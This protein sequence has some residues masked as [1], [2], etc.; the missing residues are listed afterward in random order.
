MTLRVLS[1]ADILRCWSMRDAIDW[2]RD[3][4]RLYSGGLVERGLHRWIYTDAPHGV[5]GFLPGVIK[6]GGGFGIKMLSAF[7]DEVTT[8]YVTRGLVLVADGRTGEPRA[9]LEGGAVTDLRTGAATGL[10]I[11]LLA[12][13]SARVGAMFGAGHVA[14]NQI[15]AMCEIRDIETVWLFSRTRSKALQFIETM[16][17]KGGRIPR[18]WHLASSPREAVADA[19]IVITATTTSTPLF[20]GRDLRQGACVIAAGGCVPESGEVDVETIRRCAKVVVDM[21]ET[22]ACGELAVPL[23]QGVIGAADVAELGE[24]VLSSR[25]GRERDDEIT[26]CKTIGVPVQ[27]LVT[28]QRLLARAEALGLG[29]VVEL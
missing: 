10:A 8:R 27:D 25:P 26:F 13:R 18:D 29:R 23:A 1:E 9:L 24:L 14:L 4:F 6:D 20:D 3:A 21:K 16:R 19:D 7:T 17:A 12:K 5:I 15:E 22:C 28:G 11:D 2:Q